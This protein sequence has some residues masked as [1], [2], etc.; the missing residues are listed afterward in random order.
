MA[1]S[2][3]KPVLELNEIVK[4]Y[5]GERLVLD[6]MNLTVEK[7]EVIAVIG[8]SGCG[9]STLLRCING[10]EDIQGGSI[11]L[12]GEVITGSKTEWNKI[13]ERVGMVFQ[14]YELFPT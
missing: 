14:S 2:F 9:K 11:A 4:I 3:E 13:R 8:P 10:L 5:D 6:R 12:D 1:D 7:S